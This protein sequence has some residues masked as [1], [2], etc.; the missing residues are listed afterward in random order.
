[1]YFNEKYYC[2]GLINPLENI[3][4]ISC[5]YKMLMAY[6]KRLASSAVIASVMQLS[7]MHFCTQITSRMS[8]RRGGAK[9]GVMRNMF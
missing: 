8:Q 6:K 7:E 5:R 2:V 3:F 4:S 1:M 9:Y